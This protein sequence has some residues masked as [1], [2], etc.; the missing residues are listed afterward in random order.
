[1]LVTEAPPP[2]RPSQSTFSP[3]DVESRAG[4]QPSGRHRALRLCPAGLSPLLGCFAGW[5]AAGCVKATLAFHL[6]G[7]G[8]RAGRGQLEGQKPE[9]A[10]ESPCVAPAQVSVLVAAP[11]RTG[12][13]KGSAGLSGRRGA[14]ARRG[15]CPWRLARN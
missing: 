9:A 2:Q 1:M 15:G 7:G 14:S 3:S 13:G 8:E 11:G 4:G 12:A 6:A 10:A 5:P